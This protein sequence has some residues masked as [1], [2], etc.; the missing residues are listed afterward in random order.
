MAE[1]NQRTLPGV[2]PTAPAQPSAGEVARAAAGVACD[3]PVIADLLRRKA[4]GLKLMPEEYGAIGAWKA[5][6][7]NANAHRRKRGEAGPVA[8]PRPEPLPVR[9]EPV[10]IRQGP[11]VKPVPGMPPPSPPVAVQPQ[12]E[13][14]R[15]PL[16]AGDA[17]FVSR[18]VGAIL[19]S[20]DSIGRRM[21]AATA[22]EAGATGATLA[23]FEGAKVVSDDHRTVLMDTAPL[24]CEAFGVDPKHVPVGAFLGTA[25]LAL[26]DFYQAIAELREMKAKMGE[27]RQKLE[28]AQRNSQPKTGDGVTAK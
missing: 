5:K 10:A 23:R 18:T 20:L 8:G 3:D 7:T 27:E 13:D 28:A 11:V 2:A 24:V 21:L 12:V 22:R 14:V 25:G 19:T 6:V 16:S 15:L 1:T 17:G 4:A 26:C 9:P